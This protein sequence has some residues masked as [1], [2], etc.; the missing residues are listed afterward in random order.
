M[1]LLLIHADYMEY[2]VK[3][4][5]KLAEPFDGKGERVEEVL[6]AFTSVERGD[7]EDVVRRAAEAIREVAEKVNARR[8][9]IYPYAHLS[10]NLA[11][12]DTAVRTF[13]EA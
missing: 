7:N 4:K 11:D 2:E 9:M 6:V 13:E 8:I 1:K 12:A 5:T 3:K 10:S